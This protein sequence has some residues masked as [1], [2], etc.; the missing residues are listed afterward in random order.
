V[1]DLDYRLAD[2]IIVK[3]LTNVDERLKDLCP[4]FLIIAGINTHACILTTVI[5]A[6]QLDYEV[7]LATQCI[8]SYDE[9][10]H[11]MTKHYLQGTIAH[12]L[13]NNEILKML[14]GGAV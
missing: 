2:T 8:P 9:A 12:L 11:E 13:P 6:F 1:A 3:K 4:E 5:D 10:H 7:V 14:T